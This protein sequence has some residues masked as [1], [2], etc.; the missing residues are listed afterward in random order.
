MAA[1]SIARRR[2][3]DDVDAVALRE[4][5]VAVGERF[6]R[7]KTGKI[8]VAEKAG[9]I[10]RLWL[11]QRDIEAL[12]PIAKY[13]ETVEPPTPPPI[14][15]TRG[16]VWLARHSRS[17]AKARAGRPPN[18]RRVQFHRGLLSLACAAR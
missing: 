12:E 13:L 7:P 8:E 14:T 6:E 1:G 18:S 4:R 3:M 5:L 10:A 11:D 15:T 2:I 17:A 9:R 16:L